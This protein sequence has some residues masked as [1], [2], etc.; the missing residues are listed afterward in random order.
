MPDKRRKSREELT[1]ELPSATPE[2]AEKSPEERAQTEREGEAD[3]RG[4]PEGDF[5]AVSDQDQQEINDLFRLIHSEG[6]LTAG[7]YDVKSD[8]ENT[9]VSLSVLLPSSGGLPGE[10]EGGEGGE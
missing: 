1:E 10:G 8:G 6:Y 9:L 5:T 4:A 2:E 3:S 7:T